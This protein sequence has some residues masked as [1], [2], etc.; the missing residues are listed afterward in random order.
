[1]DRE[2]NLCYFVFRTTLF[3]KEVMTM[4]TLLFLCIGIFQIVMG[5]IV[6]LIEEGHSSRRMKHRDPTEMEP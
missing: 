4:N 2:R 3:R 1:M 5:L 6:V